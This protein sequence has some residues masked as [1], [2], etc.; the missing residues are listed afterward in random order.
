MLSNSYDYFL[1]A[2]VDAPAQTF[3]YLLNINILE[4]AR[5][6]HKKVIQIQNAIPQ[7]LPTQFLWFYGSILEAMPKMPA[8][9]LLSSISYS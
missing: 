7:Q 2:L 9:T 6:N 4:T 8:H 1:S 3:A 5:P